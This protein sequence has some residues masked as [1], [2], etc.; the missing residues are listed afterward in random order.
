MP[1]T[2]PDIPSTDTLAASRQKLLD[3]DEASRS[4]F[5]G[6]AFPTSG[7]V[8]GMRCHR[9]DQNKIYVLRDTTPTWIEVEDISASTGRAPNA[10]N[11]GGYP[12]STTAAAN[13]I[14]VYNASAQLVGSITGNAATATTLATARSIGMTGDVTWS[15]ASFNGSAN[16]TAAATLANTAVTAG[17][18][19]AANITVDSKGRITAASSNSSLVSAF[20]GR[21]GSVS[22][23][24]GDVTGALGFTP[25][26][27]TNTTFGVLNVNSTAPQINMNDSDWGVRYIHSNSGLLGFLRSDGNWGFYENNSGQLW[28][29]NYGWLHDVFFNTVGNC[30]AFA[31]GAGN[32]GNCPPASTAINCYGGGN[33]SRINL[34]LVDA[35]GQVQLRGVNQLYNC[36]CNCACK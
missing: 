2:Y 13:T 17:S 28:A 5:S 31:G 22:L 6:T 3:R 29:S 26:N 25:M 10:A 4:S 12:A 35:G 7:L 33:V 18:Y 1:Q 34:E 8:V 14:P 27:S 15:I 16:V 30:L 36:N 24:S 11:L 23:T 9:T 20:N 32:T 19:T 21:T